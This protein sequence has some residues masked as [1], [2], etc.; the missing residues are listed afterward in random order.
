MEIKIVER[1]A[2]EMC[3]GTVRKMRRREAEEEF[4]AQNREDREKREHRKRIKKD[5]TNQDEYSEFLT[6]EMS[7]REGC[8]CNARTARR[9]KYEA[10][11]KKV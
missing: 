8:A 5:V 10:A 6:S 11:A 2:R 1:G 9:R 7:S 4:G 3:N